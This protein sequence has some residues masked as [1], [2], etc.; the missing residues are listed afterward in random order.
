[1]SCA[2]HMV[3]M[4]VLQVMYQTTVWLWHPAYIHVHNYALVGGAPEAYSSRHV[5]ASEWVILRDSCSH[6]LHD[7]WKLRPKTCNAS[8]TQYCLEMKLVNFGLVHVALLSNYGMIYSP[9]W[10][11]P[12]IQSS[13]KNKSLTAGCLS[14]G[15]FN[16]YNKSD[17]SPSEICGER[18][19]QSYSA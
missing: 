19:C 14:T 3:Q 8:L 6:F 18:D 12:A 11:L 4:V 2:D 10:L 15:Q 17:G 16:L 1:M 13:A 9:R 5:F 7:R